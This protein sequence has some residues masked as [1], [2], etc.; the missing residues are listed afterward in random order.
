MLPTPN[1]KNVDYE[2][3]Y[4]PAEDSFLLLDCLEEECEFIQS[5]F[6]DII[7][8][9]TEIG[10]GSGIV[11]TFLYKNILPKAIFIA[12]DINPHACEAIVNTVKLNKGDNNTLKIPNL[13]DSCQM[14]LTSAI[15]S[16]TIDLLVF[17]PPYVPATEVPDIPND[18]EDDTWLDLALLG[19]ED[20]M[21]TTWKLLDDLDTILSPTK[22]VAYILFCARNNPDKV[23]EIMRSRG[24]NV[25]TVILRKAGWEVLSILKFTRV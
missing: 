25:E 9:V 23:A 14:N 20:G 12:T 15:K 17:N 6:K 2:R 16:E 13:V 19:G 21:V 8:M 11:T 18:P 24:W 1:V 10:G 5:R 4:E 22:G 3:V 7:P